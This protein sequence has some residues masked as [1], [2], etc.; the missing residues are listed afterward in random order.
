MDGLS[1]LELILIYAFAFCAAA[2]GAAGC[3]TTSAPDA[4]GSVTPLTYLNNALAACPSL[5]PVTLPMSFDQRR[6]A[7]PKEEGERKTPHGE[8]ERERERDR[9]R[10]RETER[11][12][13]RQ[14]ETERQRERGGKVSNH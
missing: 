13:E 6:L 1:E 2:A 14:R 8:R 10:Q 9:E 5:Q 4:G 3:R 12:R 7:L 11:D